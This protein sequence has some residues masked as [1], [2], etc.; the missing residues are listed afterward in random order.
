MIKV[1]RSKMTCEGMKSNLYTTDRKY[2]TS[3]FEYSIKSGFE[4]EP[5]M[6]DKQMIPHFNALDVGSKT[7]QEQQCSFIRDDHATFL[8]KSTL[9]KE[10]VGESPL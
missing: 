6:L 1:I 4:R 5:L 9:F 3:G 2:Q 8:V 7:F 10:D